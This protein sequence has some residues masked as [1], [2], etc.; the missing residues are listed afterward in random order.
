MLID[1]TAE[2]SPLERLQSDNISGSLPQN[3]LGV[4][5]N[6]DYEKIEA[7]IISQVAIQTELERISASNITDTSEV[8]S[9]I[10][11]VFLKIPFQVTLE[12]NT[13]S[14]PVYSL[15]S[16]QGNTET[17]FTFNIYRSNTYLN[18]YN[19][20]DPTK[21]N[22]F[23]SDAEFEKL[24]VLNNVMDYQ[25][26][27]SLSEK[28]NDTMIVINR[29]LHDNT[30]FTKDTI[31]LSVSGTGT[32]IPFAR[33]PLDKDKIEALFLDKFGSSEFASQD[34]FNDYFRG[35]ILEAKGTD[36]SLASLS[37]NNSTA[38][39]NP[40]IEIYYTN[41]VLRIGT[42]D[43][44]KTV[45]KNNSFQ[46]SGFRVNKFKMEDRNYTV[47]TEV[48]VQGLAGSEAKINLF[49]A[50]ANGNG[51]PD[52][53]DELKENEWLIND[54]SIS[55]YINQSADTS[56]IPNRL[57]LYKSDED[58]INPVLSQIKD[59]ITESGFNGIDGFLV[60]DA[61]GKAEKYTFKITDYLSDLITGEISNVSTLKVKAFNTSD[62][63]IAL[64]DTIFNNYSWTPKA[65]TLFNNDA[66]NGDKKAQLKILYSEK[67]N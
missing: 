39:L 32:P 55:L 38:S 43:T 1:I 65:V 51:V 25:F 24:E 27:T 23:Y 13:T 67:K 5:A 4:Y 15:D 33:I 11:T 40:S 17:A 29:K 48:K 59:A 50:D 45:K 57:Y 54:A 12:D 19:P 21:I 62:L 64:A 41:S 14:G 37:F 30:V 61:N 42:Q 60:R 49:G 52:K 9:V 34:A 28:S 46:L 31:K 7:S 35:V 22:S 20:I 16:V 63:P 47:N 66:S 8:V 26:K 44:I 36:G 56:Y 3:L 6:A 18:Q 2:N 10:D 58:P 53:L